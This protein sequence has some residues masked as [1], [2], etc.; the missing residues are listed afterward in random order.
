MTDVIHHVPDLNSLFENLYKKIKQDSLVCILTE[1][2]EQIEHRWYNKYFPSLAKNEKQRYPDIDKIVSY[3]VKNGFSE[4]IIDT[5]KNPEENEIS[6][7][8]IK[9]VEEKN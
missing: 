8:F 5:K 4:V 3:A 1:S 9:M 6:E 2:W 7:R